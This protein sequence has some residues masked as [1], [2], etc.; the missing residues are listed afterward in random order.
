ML[1]ATDENIVYNP[2]CYASFLPVFVPDSNQVY[3]LNFSSQD[4]VETHWDF[5]DGTSSDQLMPI[6]VFPGSGSYT[7]T[8]TVVT[9]AG[10]TNAYSATINLAGESFTA[11]PAYSFRTTTDVDEPQAAPIRVK[12]FPNPVSTE[13][14]V[15]LKQPSSG[16]LQWRILNLNGQLVQ[17]GQRAMS[18]TEDRFSIQTIDLPTGVYALQLISEAG[19]VTKKFVKDG[20]R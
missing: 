12:V 9:E 5:G 18:G 10:C 17:Q 1:V 11:N 2:E 7:V 3:F 6:H 14:W 4:V 13:L 15:D 19:M 20:S 16:N 8:L